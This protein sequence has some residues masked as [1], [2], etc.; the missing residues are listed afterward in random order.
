MRVWAA[1]IALLLAFPALA[2]AQQNGK[3]DDDMQGMPGM[4][5][6]QMQGMNMG[7]SDLMTMHPETFLQEIV[8][9][10]GS[11]TSAEP[12]STP[13]PMLMTTKGKW[14][15][16]FH[17]NVF[18]LD[19]QQ[20]SARGADKFFSTNWFMGMAQRPA[21]PGVFTAR[22]MI[23]LEPA[24]ITG[25]QYPLLFQQGETAYG[26]PIEDGQH[27]HNFFMELAVLYDLKLG[28]DGLLSF[29][30][31]PIGDPA[32][33]PIAYPHRASASEDPLATLGHHQEDSTHIAEDVITVGVTYRIA[34]I[35]A[36]GFHGQEPDENRW[37]FNQGNI[38]S[39]STRL[40]LQPGKNWSGQYSYGRLASPEALFPSENQER[41]TASVMY[42]RPLRNGNWASSLIWGRTKSLEDHS[43]FDSYALE[44][45]L[46]FLTH[47]HV[48]TRIENAE[49]SNELLL[50]ENVPP[51]NFQEKPIGKVQAYTLGYDRD[52]DLIP[53]VASAIGAQVTVYG[54]GENLKPVYGGHPAGVAV[55]LRIRPFSG[56]ER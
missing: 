44:S 19:E 56:Q 1:I 30:A 3:K 26:K 16:M 17:A 23:S 41:M 35:E 10:A 40:T 45:T 37:N 6:A 47:N 54:V 53:H 36:S 42:N 5:A 20:S 18:V 7:G 28:K 8:R 9:H 39:W 24:T 2:G 22:A 29:Y 27:P 46:R 12:D 4:D 14:A 34:R 21:G 52:F 50:G 55:F 51:P 38:D 11:G 15:L 25:R 13:V 48:W 33:G 31:A 43:I 49:R 32:I